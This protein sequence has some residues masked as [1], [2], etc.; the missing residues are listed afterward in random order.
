VETTG[1]DVENTSAGVEGTGAGVEDV[2]V[3]RDEGGTGGGASA[4]PPI[5]EDVE[6]PDGGI[7][8]RPPGAECGCSTS[9][10]DRAAAEES[11]AT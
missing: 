6:G 1:V 5:L 2:G 9:I 8:P 11:P 7:E 10:D 3:V 4:L